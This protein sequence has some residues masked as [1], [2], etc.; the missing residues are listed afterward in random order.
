MIDHK[1]DL[2]LRTNYVSDLSESL[3]HNFVGLTN[4]DTSKESTSLVQ[5]RYFK[6]ISKKYE[7]LDIARNGGSSIISDNK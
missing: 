3:S 1:Q 6:F 7:K 5:D 4:I 2:L